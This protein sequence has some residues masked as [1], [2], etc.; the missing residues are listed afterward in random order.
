LVGAYPIYSQPGYVTSNNL[1]QTSLIICPVD[2]SPYSLQSIVVNNPGSFS[3]VTLK[4]QDVP[5]SG[6]NTGKAR[7]SVLVFDNLP[8]S[9]CYTLNFPSAVSPVMDLQVQFLYNSTNNA[10]TRSVPPGYGYGNY[11]PPPVSN[12]NAG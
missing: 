11:V 1:A 10:G 8:T 12:Q 4:A 7:G 9:R 6:A 5:N 3:G 2:Q